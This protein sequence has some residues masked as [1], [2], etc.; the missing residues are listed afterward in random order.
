[1]RFLKQTTYIRYVIAKLQNLFKSACWF[2]FTEDSLKIKKSVTSFQATFFIEFVDEKFYF[3]ILCK[4]AKFHYQ[5]VFT[6]QVPKWLFQEWKE[7]LKWN[8][9]HSFLF[10]NCYLLDRKRQAKM[11]RTQPLSSLI[12]LG[13]HWYKLIQCYAKVKADKKYEVNLGVTRTC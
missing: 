2:L 13:E 10:H 4:L 11:H 6:S 3:V 1:M 8:K 12:R 5:T 9:K 7:L